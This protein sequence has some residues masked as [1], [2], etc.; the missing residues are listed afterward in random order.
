MTIISR[1][2]G[3]YRSMMRSSLITLCIAALLVFPAAAQ[4]KKTGSQPTAKKAAAAET[5]SEP[6]AKVGDATADEADT[7][8][9]KTSDDASS[10]DPAAAEFDKVFA[11]WRE[12]LSKMQDLRARYIA[13]PRKGNLRQPIKAEYVKDVLCDRLGLDT[14]VTTLGHIQRGGRPCAWDRILVSLV[15]LRSF[16]DANPN[17]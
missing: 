9:Q 13:T 16:A 5:K 11:Q 10:D 6:A 1:P 12:L 4:E 2:Y 14:R 8:A 3:K 15:L 7:G 17:H